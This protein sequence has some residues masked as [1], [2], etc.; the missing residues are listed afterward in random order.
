M[1][2][3]R[4][5][6]IF[7]LCILLAL[8]PAVS[9]N[10]GPMSWEGAVGSGSLV[11]EENSPI[12]VKNEVLT[13]DI[14][15]FPAEYYA[16]A[17][18]LGGYC[19]ATVTAAYT[20]YN[21]T[22][23]DVTATLLFPY[24]VMPDY[25]GIYREEHPRAVEVLESMCG[26]WADGKALAVTKRASLHDPGQDFDIKQ[27]E[28]LH[29]NDMEHPFYRPDLT[30]TEY[31]YEV[32]GVDHE[33]YD[34]ADWGAQIQSDPS[35]RKILVRDADGWAA[36]EDHVLVHG[37]VDH[38]TQTDK[39][40]VYVIG[41]P[42]EQQPRWQIYE[43]GACEAVIDGSVELIHTETMTLLELATQARQDSYGISIP[44]WYNAFVQDLIR[45]EFSQGCIE[46]EVVTRVDL[47]AMYWYQYELTVPA[48][49]IV[50]NTVTA[51]IYPDVHTGWDP[52]IYT[53]EYLLSPARGW[54]DFGT[55][56]IHVDTPYH[57]IQSNLEGFQKTG[58]G[59]VLQLDELPEKELTFILSTAGNPARPGT[60]RGW[61]LLLP[62]LAA[63]A[64]FVGRRR[65]K[66]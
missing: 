52:A 2:R 26:V 22:D 3:I 36:E 45:R 29:G 59:Y 9:A 47:N 64:V 31:V 1:A 20:F 21:P 54:A 23:R 51:P 12:Q 33:A 15:Q 8:V 38:R 10:S 18:Q 58:G 44:D 4:D 27:A 40:S 37:G 57:L 25:A 16:T 46:P 43:N 17:D 39:F 41:A 28:L 42:F 53:Y 34:A 24:G 63:V 14:Q 11:V 50:E 49:G 6:L 7:A 48:G 65:K 56:E 66:A 30:V 60:H 5:I 13:F 32:S 55:L 62:I 19:G 35:L 61:F